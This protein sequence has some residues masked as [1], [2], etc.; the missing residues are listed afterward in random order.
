MK[1]ATPMIMTA[2]EKDIHHFAEI[3]SALDTSSVS[4]VK[5]FILQMPTPRRS[6]LN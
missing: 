4:E 3:I 6:H 2:R 1:P 5:V